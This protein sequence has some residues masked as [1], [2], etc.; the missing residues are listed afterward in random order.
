MQEQVWYWL[1]AIPAAMLVGMGKGGLP[2]VGMLGVPLLSLVMHPLEA[3]GLLLPIYVVTDIVGLWF[4][5][6]EFSARNLA[7]LIPA[8]AL[9][10]LIGWA[11]VSVLPEPAVTLAVGLIGVGFCLNLWLR[12]AVVEKKPADV[13]RG[14][15]W[16]AIT[17][18]TSF[19][20]HS[21]GPPFQVYVLP[22]KLEKMVYA[23]TSTIVFAAVNAMK[24]VPYVALGQINAESIRS[25]VYLM[26]FGAMAVLLGVRLTRIVPEKIF[27][28]AVQ[29]A[30]FLVSLKLIWDGA[31]AL[32]A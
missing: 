27:F 26:P 15:F 18:L 31:H 24:L 23:G 21:G 8:S 13:P 12:P 4:Y 30:L 28:L 25:A 19:V 16:G 3:A 29:I 20:S 1:M 6:R 22:Q 11:S 10:I 7:I 17:G 2:V 32:R 14:V 5:R 9:G